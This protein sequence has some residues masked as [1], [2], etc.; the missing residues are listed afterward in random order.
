MILRGKKCDLNGKRVI[1][2]RERNSEIGD[3]HV[4]IALYSQMI[5]PKKTKIGEKVTYHLFFRTV[6]IMKD[7]NLETCIF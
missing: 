2:K 6:L 5:L 3:F 7:W 4:F 1:Y